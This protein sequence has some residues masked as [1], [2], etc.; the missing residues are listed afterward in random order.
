MLEKINLQKFV[1]DLEKSG[2]AFRKREPI[3]LELIT[4]CS[5]KLF[6]RHS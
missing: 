6:H 2:S 4:L 5:E 3:E 1:T